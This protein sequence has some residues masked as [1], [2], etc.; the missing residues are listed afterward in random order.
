MA[1]ASRQLTDEHGHGGGWSGGREGKKE[2]A[3]GAV[4]AGRRRRVRGRGGRARGGEG[5][6]EQY[7]AARESGSNA[8]T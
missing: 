4:G 3:T 6:E 7:S 5:E 1:G 2:A 8:R